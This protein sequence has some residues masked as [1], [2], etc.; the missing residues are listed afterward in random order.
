MSVLGKKEI[1][2]LLG[3]D[4][5]ED[6]AEK[7]KVLFEGAVSSKLEDEKRIFEAE[8]NM[9]ID[10]AERLHEAEKEKILDEAERLH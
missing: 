5:S 3:D 6:V 4:I 1:T 7:I 10:E 2:A 8:K 9:I